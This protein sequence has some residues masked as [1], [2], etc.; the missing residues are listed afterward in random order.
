M[1]LSD[2]ARAVFHHGLAETDLAIPD[3]HNFPAMANREYGCTVHHNQ[4][5][6]ED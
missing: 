4:S 5:L 6:V 3:D 1:E 2:L